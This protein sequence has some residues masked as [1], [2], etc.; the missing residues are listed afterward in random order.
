MTTYSSTSHSI[1][2]K[3]LILGVGNPL[4]GDDGVGPEVIRLLQGD[5]LT[6]NADLLDG[7]TDGLNL[8]EDI[9]AYER[10]IIIDAVDM[11]AP[12]GT[13]RVFS[14]D[15]AKINIVSEALSTHGFG[16]GEVIALLQQLGCKT[17][18]TIIGVQPRSTNFGEPMSEE[19][20]GAVDQVLSLVSKLASA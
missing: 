12:V 15:E 1:P 7:G 3:T 4:R 19:V 13:V 10:A 2:M 11:R 18:L 5:Q 6:E 8:I 20:A 9:Q 14:P 16:L 17:E